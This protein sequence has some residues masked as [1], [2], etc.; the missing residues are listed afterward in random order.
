VNIGDSSVNSGGPSTNALD[1]Q[2]TNFDREFLR[3]P[4]DNGPRPPG[5]LDKFF[6]SGPTNVDPD[7]TLTPPPTED[8][9]DDSLDWILDKLPEE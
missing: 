5:D 1:F 8:Q 9:E 3:T 2:D 7:W 6:P 4:L